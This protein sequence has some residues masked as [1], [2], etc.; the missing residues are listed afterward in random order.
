MLNA[1]YFDFFINNTPDY[2]RQSILKYIG[3][4]S[5]YPDIRHMIGSIYFSR[6]EMGAN[7]GLI[8]DAIT[9]FGVIGIVIMPIMIAIALRFFDNC[10]KGLNKR[11]Y[12]ALCVLVSYYFI[13]SFFFTILLTHGFLA[14]CIVFYILPR[15]S[16]TK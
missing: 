9:N 6:P 8:S 15:D 10:V 16:K 4:Q 12:V 11:F 5:P 13:S 3:I 2:F 1:Y 7:S 14:L